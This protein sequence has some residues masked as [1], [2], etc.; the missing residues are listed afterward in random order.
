PRNPKSAAIA[1]WASPTPIAAAATN[2]IYFILSLPSPRGPRCKLDRLTKHHGTACFVT[3]PMTCCVAATSPFL[4]KVSKISC[5]RPMTPTAGVL[6]GAG[7][8]VPGPA[9]LTSPRRTPF[10]PYFTF[11]NS[12]YA[13]LG[14]ANANRDCLSPKLLMS[15]Y[16]RGDDGGFQNSQ[17]MENIWAVEII[18]LR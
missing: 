10:L 2:A 9:A 15:F 5:L 12:H 3:I 6:A 1:L 18:A 11:K 14:R 13:S 16:E 8:G 4:K 7:Q 17:R